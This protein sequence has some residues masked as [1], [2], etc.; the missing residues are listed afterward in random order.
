MTSTVEPVSFKK[1]LARL[2]RGEPLSVGTL[3]GFGLS[4]FHSS[5]LARNGWLERLGRD[6]YLVPGADVDRDGALA[7]LAPRIPGL[8]VAGKTALAWRGVRHHLAVKER[9]SLWADQPARLPPWFTARFDARLQSTRIFDEKMSRSMGLQPLPNGRAE[10]LVSVPERALLE[11]LSDVGKSQSLDEARQLV[12]SLR[13]LR[14]TVLDALLRHLTRIKVARLAE[15]LASQSQLPWA[16]VARK[17]SERLGGGGR[18]VAV[19]RTG[20]RIDLRRH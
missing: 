14:G 13:S 20:E 8:H 10:I 15:L 3:R 7:Y 5:W 11:L 9:L 1:V 12:E 4:E 2:P 16:P 6:A 18:W 19:S 17:H